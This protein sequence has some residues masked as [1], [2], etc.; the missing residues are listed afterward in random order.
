[1]TAGVLWTQAQEA[2]D[3]GDPEAAYLQALRA[4]ELAREGG[5]PAQAGE[6]LRRALEVFGDRAAIQLEAGRI[7]DEEGASLARRSRRC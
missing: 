3:A 4:L 7:L 2:L 1:M 5:D 6:I